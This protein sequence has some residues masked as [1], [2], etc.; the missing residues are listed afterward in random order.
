MPLKDCALKDRLNL[1]L[2]KKGLTQSE[3]A[4]KLHVSRQAVQ[5]WAS[6]RSEPKGTNLANLCEYFDVSPEWMTKGAHE[7]LSGQAVTAA[8]EEESGEIPDAYVEIPEYQIVFAAGDG[9]DDT[10]TWEE[11]KDGDKAV[12]R[13]EFFQ[14]MRIRPEDC[15]RWTVEGDS[16]EPF[17]C[18][19]D[20]VL[21]LREKC[22][23]APF[24][25]DGGVYCISPCGRRRAK[26]LYEGAKGKI[27][28]HS[29][30]PRYPEEVVEP[31]DREYFR[32]L[33]KVIERC[34]L[35]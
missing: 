35:T 3:L 21:V 11:L 22:P 4:E 10:P 32:V 12:Y 6:G 23:E 33:G 29:D 14:K 31:E 2:A 26:R 19:H 5:F 16:M 25:V 13:R 34:G 9:P 17:L 20:K 7:E 24:I 18:D 15:V 28:I 27:I 30:N 1:L 8:P